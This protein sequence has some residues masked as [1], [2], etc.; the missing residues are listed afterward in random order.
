MSERRPRRR[1]LTYANVAATL[2]LLLAISGT[3][4]AAGWV[5]SKDIKNY[6]IKPVDMSS[7]VWTTALPPAVS[8]YK[9]NFGTITG[10]SETT[11]GRI[12]IWPGEW[13]V[14]G[15]LTLWNEGPGA[16]VH[17][18]LHAG[19]DTDVAG[20]PIE[21]T[22]MTDFGETTA[23]TVVHTATGYEDVT[24]TCNP[25]GGGPVH[26]FDVKLTAVQLGWLSNNAMP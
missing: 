21:A 23:L 8:G 20:E 15:K 12:S 6:T 11:V 25:H 19:A 1:R 24:M 9:N 17:C 10:T 16:I 14:I 22:G 4:Y 26:V 18:Y 5:T 13:L 2:A 3:A 7:T